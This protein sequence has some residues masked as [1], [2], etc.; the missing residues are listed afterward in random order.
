MHVRVTFFF[1]FS[2][3][4]LV[5][6][7][8]LKRSLKKIM[9]EMMNIVKREYTISH[10]HTFTGFD[11]YREIMF[12]QIANDRKLVLGKILKYLPCW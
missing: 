6:I 10:V 7:G 8:K 1:N 4:L 9:L 11:F 2:F 5:V 12:L 3:I